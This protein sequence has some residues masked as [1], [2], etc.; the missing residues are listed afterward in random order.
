[1]P[2]DA[3]KAVSQTASESYKTVLDPEAF[4]SALVHGDL[5]DHLTPQVSTMLDE[6]PLPLI[7]AAIA[8]V[9]G[10]RK[11]AP[12]LLWKHLIDW[13]HALHSPRAVWA[14]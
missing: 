12:K 7:V 10:Q 11:L 9:A 2:K 3:L 1:M 6:A 8:E 14:P 5:P 4:A 13:A